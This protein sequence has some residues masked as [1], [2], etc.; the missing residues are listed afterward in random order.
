MLA[1]AARDADVIAHPHDELRVVLVPD[2]IALAE[3]LA[4]LAVRGRR[5]HC[6]LVPVESDHEFHVRP[7]DDVGELLVEAQA[8]ELLLEPVVPLLLLLHA[9]LDNGDRF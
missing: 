2:E 7:E 1:E 5:R 8:R 4:Q 6:A 9:P 3:V